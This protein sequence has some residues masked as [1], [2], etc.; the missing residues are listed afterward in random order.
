MNYSLYKTDIAK[1]KDKKVLSTAWMRLVPLLK[2]EGREMTLALVAI[3]LNSLAMLVSPFL[4]GRIVDL[5]IAQHDFHGVL[6]YSGILAL[7]GIAGLFTAYTQVKKMGGIGRRVLFNLRNSIF[8]KLQDLPVAFF[9]QNKAG[10]LISRINNDTD[11][12]NQFFSQALV[13]LMG[14]IILIIGAGIFLLVLNP[15]LGFFAMVPAFI[16]LVIT[17][18]I[19]P[20]IKKTN[21]KSLR[22]LGGLS[23]EIQEL[24]LI[25]I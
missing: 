22:T 18:L 9:N 5:Y 8:K 17:S 11:K 13:Q 20:W 6:V 4:I 25:H 16:A 19:S 14:N 3:V 7:V 12:L 10:D 23:G 15:R 24:S 1:E 21:V 2:S